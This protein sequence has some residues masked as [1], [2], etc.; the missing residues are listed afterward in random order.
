MDDGTAV[1]VKARGGRVQRVLLRANQ[2]AT[3]T[4]RYGT[5]YAGL[6]VT[7]VAL[8]GGTVR[9]PDSNLIA[10]DGTFA[11]QFSGARQPG[12]YRVFVNCGGAASTWQFWVPE[13]G[14]AGVDASIL[15]PLPAGS[16]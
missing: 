12:L 14:A 6:A 15:V 9:F 3:V 7:V 4:L 8:D 2:R 10:P 16:K 13:P 1:S 11:L 5:N